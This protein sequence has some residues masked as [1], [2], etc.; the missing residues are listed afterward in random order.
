MKKIL[1]LAG[2]ISLGLFLF[3]SCKKETPLPTVSFT[4]KVESNVVT[5]SAVVTNDTKYEWDFGDGSYINTLH[6][7]VHTY[8]E[9]GKD[10]T[11]SL[12]II[13]AG[14]RVTVTNKVTIPPKTKI[15]LL[16]GGNTASSSKKWRVSKT[17]TSFTVAYANAG[18]SIIGSYPGSILG[19]INMAPVYNDEFVF[20]GDGTMSINSKSGGIFAS[21]AYCMGNQIPMASN[22]AG[23][24]LAY[25]ASFTAPV[26]ATFAINEGKNYT[27]TTPLGPV[28]YSNVTTMSFTNGGFLGIKD[29]TSE[30]IIQKLTDTSIDAVIFYA[31]PSY[32]AQPMLAML[33]TFEVA[34]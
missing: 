3:V 21:L 19:S 11:V 34:P 27:I 28:T 23:A 18:L 12:T 33:V 7:P 4:A 1:K 25:M 24:G 5:F 13:G 2:L 9:Y 22:Y 17:A 30:C 10:F 26:G 20:A 14:G 32:G 31:H 8:G 6:A 29:F 15:Q 16:T